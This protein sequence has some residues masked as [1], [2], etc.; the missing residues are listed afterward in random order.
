M[1]SKMLV[2]I[3]AASLLIGAYM[4]VSYYKAK[5]RQEF[6]RNCLQNPFRSVEECQAAIAKKG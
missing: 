2:A 4:A 3:L 1:F 6:M 5:D